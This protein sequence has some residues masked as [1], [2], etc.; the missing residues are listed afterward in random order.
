MVVTYNGFTLKIS[1][2][3]MQQAYTMFFVLYGVTPP[4]NRNLQTIHKVFKPVANHNN[5]IIDQFNLYIYIFGKD[6]SISYPL[7]FYFSYFEKCWLH[8]QPP[9]KWVVLKTR[10]TYKKRDEWSPMFSQTNHIFGS[11]KKSPNFVQIKK[12]HTHTTT[13]TWRRWI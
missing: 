8:S 1:L 4:C 2:V 12:K 6:K 10:C 5:Y 11:W 3:D 9:H 7:K 13:T